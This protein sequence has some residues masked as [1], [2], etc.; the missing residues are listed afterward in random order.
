[1]LELGGWVA[2]GLMFHMNRALSVA[3]FL[4]IGFV[5]LLFEFVILVRLHA[6]RNLQ[7]EED[8]EDL[9]LAAE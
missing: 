5:I 7:F 9:E 2:L 3:L 6:R 8:E 1:S 4:L